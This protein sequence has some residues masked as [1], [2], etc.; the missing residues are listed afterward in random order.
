MGDERDK[1]FAEICEGQ[2]SVRFRDLV[3]VMELW[4]FSVRINTKG[5]GAIFR[6]GAFAV[7][8]NIGKPHHDPVKP[9]YVRACIGAIE[10][11]QILEA[12][13]DA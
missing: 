10:E 2:K 4:G 9:F 7:K 5:D 3:K 12:K 8:V 11:V 6:H 1:R 13:S